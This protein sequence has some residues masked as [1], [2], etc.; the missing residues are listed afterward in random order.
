MEGL[1]L[2]ELLR[3]E[4]DDPMTPNRV[5]QVRGSRNSQKSMS[6]EWFSHYDLAFLKLKRNLTP[7]PTIQSTCRCMQGRTRELT[8]QT[9]ETYYLF[10][11]N[12]CLEKAPSRDISL[13]SCVY[14]QCSCTCKLCPLHFSVQK[15]CNIL[16]LITVWLL[17]FRS[18]LQGISVK[19][20]HCEPQVC[21]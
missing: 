5:C 19:R 15:N 17:P 20:N 8:W 11:K 7:A 21:Q 10:Q 1:T 18:F 16:L 9:S 6:E 14:Y 12:N 4:E 2:S 3:S 13:N